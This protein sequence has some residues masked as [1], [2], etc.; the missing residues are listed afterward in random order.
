MPPADFRT[1]VS[2]LSSQ[3]LMYLGAYPDP[4]GRPM[5][6]LE[7]A[8]HS[9]DLLGVLEAKTAGN[10]SDEEQSH[11]DA[12]LYELRMTYVEVARAV[13]QQTIESAGLPPRGM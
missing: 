2:T 1:L 11:L 12:M 5:I 9:L 8:R 3:A 13:R 7:T 4:S 6:S 10:L